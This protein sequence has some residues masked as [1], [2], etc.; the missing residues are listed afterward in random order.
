M[1]A[2]TWWATGLAAASIVMVAACADEAVVA[3]DPVVTTPATTAVEPP[4]ETD[5]PGAPDATSEEPAEPPQETPEPEEPP[6]DPLGE[7]LAAVDAAGLPAGPESS[8]AQ[9]IGAYV[10]AAS[11][12]ALPRESILI[13]VTAMVGLELQRIGSDADP[14]RIADE[15]VEIAGRHYC[16]G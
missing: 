7:Y 9:G 6:A 8:S 3:S 16:D 4:G 11:G 1:T 12:D 10:C 5:A 13:N 14:E 15:Y 2:R